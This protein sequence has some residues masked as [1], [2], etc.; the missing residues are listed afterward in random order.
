MIK[1]NKDFLHSVL[2]VQSKSGNQTEMQYYILD[3]VLQWNDEGILIDV[4]LDEAG[5]LYLTKGE[6]K[7]GYPCVVSHMD[8]V[9]AIV[10]DNQFKIIRYGDTWHGFNPV[11]Y[12]MTGI[13]GDDKVGVFTCLEALRHFDDIK[14]AFFTDEEVG[15]VGSSQANMK[16]FDD[17]NL[18]LQADRRGN[19]DFVQYIG[20]T[21]L[22]G[23]EFSEAVTPLLDAHGYSVCKWGGITDVGELK[24]RGLKVACANMS[25]GYH[26]PHFDNEYIVLKEVENVLNLIFTIITELGSTRWDHEAIPWNYTYNKSSYKTTSYGNYNNTKSVTTTSNKT[27][28]T[29]SKEDDDDYDYTRYWQE[30]FDQEKWDSYSDGYINDRFTDYS[31]DLNDSLDLTPAP[32]SHE[33]AVCGGSSVDFDTSEEDYWCFDCH[34]YVPLTWGANDQGY[35]GTHDDES[36]DDD[37]T[38]ETILLQDR[39]LMLVTKNDL[40]KP[41]KV[42]A[43]KTKRTK[44]G[45]V[46]ILGV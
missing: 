16:W 23:K 3:K 28:G 8:T 6:G 35:E 4:D 25:A 38:L 18:V 26:N 7:N 44:K 27:K 19:D 29:S 9:H 36:D 20:G 40:P 43:N 46:T 12:E 11:K 45:K 2:S 1:L 5:N 10:P 33:C 30:K 17:C 21:D 14:V 31:V 13:G 32:S 24:D 42:T 15:C 39:E 37:K 22:F 34:T 41:K